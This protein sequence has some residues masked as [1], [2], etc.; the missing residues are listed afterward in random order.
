VVH[1]VL[2]SLL[3]ATLSFLVVVCVELA[4]SPVLLN[5]YLITCLFTFASKEASFSSSSMFLGF[6][7]NMTGA[8]GAFSSLLNQS[9]NSDLDEKSLS[10]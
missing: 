8:L 7:L 6:G 9:E 2:V 1:Q 3:L 5:A 4:Y 10:S